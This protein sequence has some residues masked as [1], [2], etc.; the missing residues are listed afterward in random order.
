MRMF[1]F[2]D[3]IIKYVKFKREK[4]EETQFCKN[5]EKETNFSPNKNIVS[6]RVKVDSLRC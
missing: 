6:V 3:F 1:L 5:F 2:C 4:G